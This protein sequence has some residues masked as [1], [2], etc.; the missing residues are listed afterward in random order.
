MKNDHRNVVSLILLQRYVDPETVTNKER[1]TQAQ[2]SGPEFLLSLKILVSAEQ[3]LAG[4]IGPVGGGGGNV[5]SFERIHIEFM[6]DS[7]GEVSGLP[8][9]HAGNIFKINLCYRQEKSI[10]DIKTN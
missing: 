8:G 3:G 6:P 10:R 9:H 2:I 5:E 4:D 7:W 1:E